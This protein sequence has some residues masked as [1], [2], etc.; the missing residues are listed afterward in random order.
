[1]YYLPV[2]GFK[3]PIDCNIRQKG[4]GVAGKETLSFLLHSTFT[5]EK[6]KSQ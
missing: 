5:E 2:S 6:S 4:P 3:K 1:M